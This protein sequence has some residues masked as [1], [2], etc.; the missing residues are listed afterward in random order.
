MKGFISLFV[1]DCAVLYCTFV[2]S[3]N[4]HS[5]RHTPVCYSTVYFTENMVVRTLRIIYIQY[6]QYN[7]L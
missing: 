3:A 1:A 4:L 5:V 7:Q 6:V 2:C